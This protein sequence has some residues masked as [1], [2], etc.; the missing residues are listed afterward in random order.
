MRS[1]IVVVLCAVLYL[2]SGCVFHPA[3]IEEPILLGRSESPDFPYVLK[4]N[5][6]ERGLIEKDS[7]DPFP[8]HHYQ[9]YIYLKRARGR[10]VWNEFVLTDIPP[11]RAVRLEAP[12]RPDYS[13]S[14]YVNISDG[15]VEIKLHTTSVKNGMPDASNIVEGPMNGVY[16]IAMEDGK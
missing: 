16:K 5:L 13:R 2:C 9:T 6:V 11:R 14:D 1:I 10:L 3:A 12:I 7:M 8:V 4:I 15:R